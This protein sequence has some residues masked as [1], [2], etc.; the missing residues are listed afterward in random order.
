M[1]VHM[2][3]C[4]NTVECDLMADTLLKTE[5]IPLDRTC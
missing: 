4:E 2:A 5:W 3:V 1:I